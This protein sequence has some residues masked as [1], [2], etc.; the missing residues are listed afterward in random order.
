[1]AEVIAQFVLLPLAVGAAMLLLPSLPWCMQCDRRI[2]PWSAAPAVGSAVLLALVAIEGSRPFAIGE[3]WHALWVTGA[4]IALGGVVSAVA[5]AAGVRGGP[6][7]P[8]RAPRISHLAL[9]A[10]PPI[11]L[12]ALRLPGL[13]TPMARI[14]IATL[15]ALAAVAARRGVRLNPRATIASMA[16]ATATLGAMLLVSGSSKLA[17]V[18]LV[19]AGVASIALLLALANASFALGGS[20]AMAMATIAIAIASCGAAYHADESAGTMWWLG[21]A[22]GPGVLAALLGQLR[23]GAVITLAMSS[24]LCAASLWQTLASVAPSDGSAA[25]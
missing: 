10:T 20:L 24:I 17:F 5:S 6:R 3:R 8:S 13:D 18:A 14:G 11:A 2:E 22:A 1:M 7:H 21:L 23:G 12:A 25:Y 15:G 4:A 16:I 9:L 19:A